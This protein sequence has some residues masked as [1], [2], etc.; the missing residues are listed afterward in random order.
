MA[1][2]KRIITAGPLV[3]EAVYPAPHPRD[4]MGARAGKRA[5][6]SEAQQRMNLKYAY[7]KLELLMAANF[8]VRDLYITLTYDDDHL[9]VSRKEAQRRMQ[10]F[11]RKLRADR[12]SKGQSIRYIYVTEHKHGDGRWH[13][14]LLLNA[15]GADFELISRLW[16]QGGAEYKTI[17]V[18]R[19]K[20]YE[21]LARYFCK[22]Q[23]DKVGLRLWSSSRNLKK[24]EKECFRVSNDT[25]LEPPPPEKATLLMDTGNVRTEYGHYRYIKYLVNGW[26]CTAN[27]KAR[28]RRRRK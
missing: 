26:S 9:P 18:D 27:P 10:A 4:S 12:Q 5:L 2:F 11:F 23:R 22:E 17:R 1:K 25:P 6:S 16:G 19:D 14:H 7:Q 28:R 20:N 8:G 15:T 13:H 3:L 21:T 24:P